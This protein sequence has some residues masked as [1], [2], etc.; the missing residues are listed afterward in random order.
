MKS[1][2][3]MILNSLQTQ[4]GW[5]GEPG[6]PVIPGGPLDPGN[7]LGPLVP[8]TP[9][10][11]Q[12]QILQKFCT[13]QLYTSFSFASTSTIKPINS[14]MTWVSCKTSHSTLSWIT[15]IT[16]APFLPWWSSSNLS[17]F[18]LASYA[19]LQS[20]YI[21]WIGILFIFAQQILHCRFYLIVY[22]IPMKFLLSV[23]YIILVAFLQIINSC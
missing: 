7:P 5:P 22:K 2:S 6:E 11:L 21:F 15:T 1:S 18:T 13:L 20:R 3:I 14:R 12:W 17:F 9:I 8:S 4:P 10:Q 19:N 16:F 23:K